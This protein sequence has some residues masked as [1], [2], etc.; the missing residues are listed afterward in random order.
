MVAICECNYIATISCIL[1]LCFSIVAFIRPFSFLN[2]LF[3]N[4]FCEFSPFSCMFCWYRVMTLGYSNSFW[5]ISILACLDS[6]THISYGLMA[7][8]LF[9]HSSTSSVKSPRLTSSAILSSQCCRRSTSDN[10]NT[11]VV[12]ESTIKSMGLG[13][14]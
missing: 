12:L 2:S 9:K 6:L 5:Y 7:G 11:F 8:S 3:S 13:Q 10:I 1:V 4:F 14:H